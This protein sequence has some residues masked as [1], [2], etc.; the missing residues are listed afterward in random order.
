MINPRVRRARRVA[1]AVTAAA[2]VAVAGA[3]CG[4]SPDAAGGPSGPL[5]LTIW[6][7]QIDKSVFEERLALAKQ[8]LPD[9]Q[10]KLVQIPDDYDTK[11]QTMIAGG[12]A[13]DVMMLAEA[14]NVLSSKGQLEDMNPALAEAGVDP[15]ATFGASTVGTYSTDGKLWA[16][17]DRSGAMALYYNKEIFD[18]Q[19]VPYPDGTWDWE[20]FRQAAT[21]LTVRDGDKVTSWG[22]AAGDWWPWYMT[23]MR[24]NGGR[25]LDDGGKPVAD[26]AEN[27]EALEFYHSLVHKDRAAPS[28]VDYANAGLDDGQADPLF[29]QGKLAMLTTGFWNV[30]SLS[31]T[32]LKWDVAPLWRGKQ[33]AVPAFGS[34][35]AVSSQSDNK[36]AA[37]KLVAFL[38][39][40]KGQQPLVTSGLDVPAN[41]AVANSPAFQQ[42]AWNT[43][44]VDLSAFTPPASAVY[45]PPLVPEWNAIQKAFTDGMDATWKGKASVRDGLAA[46]QRNLEGVLR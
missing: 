17:P 23:W 5:T 29:A 36:E 40:E 44:K 31:E 7:S 16:V 42:P 6:G 8:A 33:E 22:Y 9:I 34:A 32:D 25:V 43:K 41:L 24:Q 46:V 4:G 13:P 14:V 11:L 20:D 2:L 12:D 21:K 19:G 39:S 27:V 15:V 26:S 10:V 37:A 35:L 28:P 3:A 18:R 45:L 30:A 1:A 38:T